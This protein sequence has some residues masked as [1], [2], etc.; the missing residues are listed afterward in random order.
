[1]NVREVSVHALTRIEN[2]LRS[3]MSYETTNT[4]MA[5]RLAERS[6]MSFLCGLCVSIKDKL[7][8]PNKSALIT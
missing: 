4:C 7:S 8:Y 5:V 3:R 6:V 1:M 2:K